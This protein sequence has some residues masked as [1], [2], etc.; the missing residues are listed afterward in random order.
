M[1]L[2][3]KKK[4]KKFKTPLTTIKKMKMKMKLIVKENKNILKLY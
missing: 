2:I 1:F 4:L 3:L